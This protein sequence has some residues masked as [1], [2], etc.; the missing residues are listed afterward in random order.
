MIP[1]INDILAGLASGQYTIDQARHW[2]QQHF[3]LDEN[4]AELERRKEDP[5]TRLHNLCE[6][7][8]AEAD[9]SEFSREEWDRIDTENA[10]LRAE[11][12]ALK[13]EA[14]IHAQEA[15]TQRSTV[16]EIY[17]AITGATGEPGDWNGAEPVR[18][19]V[20]ER[21][22]LREALEAL[23]EVERRGRLMPIGAAWDAAR[24]ALSHKEPT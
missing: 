4:L 18:A 9:G 15:R 19:L 6:A 24:A 11:R 21:D 14:Q 17:Q 16:H 7:I 1:S 13:L 23:M 20:A 2:I 8:A 22:A 10:A 3:E 12:D 5:R